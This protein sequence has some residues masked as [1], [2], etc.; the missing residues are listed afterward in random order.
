MLN[1]A[2]WPKQSSEQTKIEQFLVVLLCPV[3][4]LKL[5][6]LRPEKAA[7]AVQTIKWLDMH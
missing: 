4:E 1:E 7:L 5:A 2:Y 3:Q 6:I